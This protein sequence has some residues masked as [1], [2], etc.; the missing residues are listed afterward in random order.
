MYET[1]A[2]ILVPSAESLSRHGFVRPRPCAVANQ[3]EIVPHSGDTCANDSPRPAVVAPE[4][5]DPTVVAAPTVDVAA[6]P[7]PIGLHL[8]VALVALVALAIAEPP[9]LV[10]ILATEQP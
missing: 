6:A 8:L 7:A 1:H 10:A 2:H 4:I 5:V 3:R 9:S